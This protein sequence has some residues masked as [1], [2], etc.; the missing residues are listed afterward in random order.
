M[1]NFVLCPSGDKVA[2]LEIMRFSMFSRCTFEQLQ[3]I[4]IYVCVCVYVL[5]Y[6]HNDF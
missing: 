1:S 4:H 6:V 3:C 2:S 5:V